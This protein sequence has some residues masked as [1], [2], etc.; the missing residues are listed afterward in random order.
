MRV[1]VGVM[2]KVRGKRRRVGLRA[3]PKLSDGGKYF[4]GVRHDGQISTRWGK[5]VDFCEY[6]NTPMPFYL[7]YM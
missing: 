7:A 4:V 1:G 2:V 6:V 3:G 5:T